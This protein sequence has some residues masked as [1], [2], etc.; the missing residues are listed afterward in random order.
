[1]PVLFPFMRQLFTYLNQSL[2]R[3]PE[4]ITY[5]PA[6]IIFDAA[7]EVV[8]QALFASYAKDPKQAPSPEEIA[9][10]QKLIGCY[11]ET[12]ESAPYQSIMK[13]MELFFKKEFQA[14]F[15]EETEA[16]YA[17]LSQACGRR[18]FGHDT[19]FFSQSYPLIQQVR[20]FIEQQFETT[21]K[22][23][24]NA[25]LTLSQDRP[26]ALSAKLS[27]ESDSS[28]TWGDMLS[29]KYIP[30]WLMKTIP[31]SQFAPDKAA[32]DRHRWTERHVTILKMNFLERVNTLCQYM[33]QQGHP[34]RP[35]T[36]E[37]LTAMLVA[38]R[39]V[40]DARALQ[41]M[42]TLYDALDIGE[43]ISANSNFFSPK[44]WVPSLNF[45]STIQ[46]IFIEDSIWKNV[47]PYLLR[48]ML[49]SEDYRI[50]WT[51]S[52]LSELYAINL[53]ATPNQTYTGWY[54]RP[55]EGGKEPG[56]ILSAP[57]KSK[58]VFAKYTERFIYEYYIARVLSQLGIKMA[59][60]RLHQQGKGA[61]T[62]MTA[63]LSRHYSKNGHSK[64]KSFT[65]LAALEDKAALIKQ[66]ESASDGDPFRISFA[67]L[68]LVGLAFN[69][70]DLGE[71]G[72]NVG[73]IQAQKNDGAPYYKMG[74]VDFAILV[75][76][77]SPDLTPSLI[78]NAFSDAPAFK[79][80]W[81]TLRTEDFIEAAKQLHKIIYKLPKIENMTRMVIC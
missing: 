76:D 81:E 1:M 56:F 75:T 70:S 54:A 55:K 30:F 19:P 68:L 25:F 37:K 66:L 13:L 60:S 4:P 59:E 20:A 51:K 23:A 79:G 6:S 71:H 21:R 38:Q 61:T 67:K 18:M 27:S 29:P 57:D 3:S 63:D 34:L 40:T 47:L 78:R 65:M 16:G 58:R 49:L 52:P 2:V 48:D 50:N 33:S 32:R 44:M 72:G 17:S 11:I 7:D 12:G 28:A 8:L 10:V 15:G 35:N 80:L 26:D 24:D 14:Q 69:L 74:I 42:L 73:P 46:D 53:I 5:P 31:D 64:K 77:I 41:G 36:R 22:A 9:L 39:Q 45:T 62:F 43:F